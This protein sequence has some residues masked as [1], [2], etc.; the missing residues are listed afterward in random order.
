MTPKNPSSSITVQELHRAQMSGAE[1]IVVDVRLPQEVQMVAW[2]GALNIP[3][4]ALPTRFE[5]LDP[6]KE[7]VV[8]CHHGVRSAYGAAFLRQKG[9]SALSLE[10][11]IDAWAKEIDKTL[12]TY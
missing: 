11:G 1:F 4:D 7:I 2:P 10:G 9:F 5:I 3:L 6:A 12:A 8:I